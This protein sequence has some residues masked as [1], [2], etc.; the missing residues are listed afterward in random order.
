MFAEDLLR[1]KI[2]T[3][4]LDNG[5]FIDG[6]HRFLST[7]VFSFSVKVTGLGVRAERV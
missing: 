5:S 7:K 2:C 6:I 3:Y 1:D 4:R